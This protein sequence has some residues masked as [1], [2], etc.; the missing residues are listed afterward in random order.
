[1]RTVELV[2]ALALA[3]DLG[4]G[5]P[6]EHSLRTAIL[7]VRLGSLAGVSDHELADAYYAGLMHSS[8]CTS[9]AHELAALYGDDIRPRVEFATVDVARL[10]DLG[11]FA[12]ARASDRAPAL[13]RP[14]VAAGVLAAG[15]PVMRRGFAMHCEVAR[16]LAARLTLPETVQAALGYV[17]ER[18]DGKGF[19]AGARGESIPAAAR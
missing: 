10:D 12:W 8:G 18:W 1:M 11:R 3:T 16:R 7:A 17:F 19:P 6:L 2:G 13:L 5:Q 14:L 9:D 4:T 15:R